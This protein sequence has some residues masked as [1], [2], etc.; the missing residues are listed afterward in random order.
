M[1]RTKIDNHTEIRK[2]LLSNGYPPLANYDKRCFLENWPNLVIDAALVTSR[3]WV[4]R[5][6]AT[7]IRND[8][9]SFL[10]VD[11][12]DPALNAAIVS[13]LFALFPSGP[14]LERGTTASCKKGFLFRCE[15]AFGILRSRRYTLPGS[16]EVQ[17]VEIFSCGPN[18]QIGGFGA[19]KRDK[20]GTIL[21]EYVWP[22]DSPLDVKLID[23]PLLTEQLA[24]LM[25]EAAEQVFTD[26]GCVPVPGSEREKGGGQDVYDLT[27]DMVFECQ[28]GVARTLAGLK[29]ALKGTDNIRCSSSWRGEGFDNTTACIARMDRQGRLLVTDFHNDSKHHE[30]AFR[31]VEPEEIRLDEASLQQAEPVAEV[32][33]EH[34][35][36]AI[37]RQ[38][39]ALIK[40]SYAYCKTSKTPIVPLDA[41]NDDDCCTLAN[42][43]ISMLPYCG[44]EIGPR[45]GVRKINPVDIWLTDPEHIAIRGKQMRPDIPTQLFTEQGHQ[46]LNTYHAPDH[47]VAGG[48]ATLLIQFMEQIA[49]DEA[50]RNYF[51]QWLAYKYRHPWVPGPGIVMVARNKFGTGRGRLAKLI[52]KLFGPAYVRRLPFHI[53]A[54]KSYQ[55]QY[56]TYA[57]ESLF[58]IVNETQELQGQAKWSVSQDTYAHIRE[59]IEPSA[60]PREII[61][62]GVNARQMLSFCSY[63]IMLNDISSIPIPEEDRRLGALENGEPQP[64]A[65]WLALEQAMADPANIA[66]FARWLLT[67]DLTGYSPFTTP[68]MTDTK[69]DMAWAGLSD[70]E[71]TLHDVLCYLKGR[72]EIFSLAH[73]LIGMRAL[74]H[75]QHLPQGWEQV[76]PKIIQQKF[77]RIGTADGA[78]WKPQFFGHRHPA[79]AWAAG[80]AK[81]WTNMDPG[82]I[83]AELRKAGPD[84]T[85]DFGIAVRNFGD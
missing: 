82:F 51:L 69:R 83:R 44:D 8:N 36:M 78:N 27:D 79:Y 37:A 60:E 67:I 3:D 31:P 61:S 13:V 63:L 19:H 42:F 55:S 12:S 39:A 6:S 72:S 29:A 73:I 4:K 68:P 18:R 14:V 38:A 46:W 5:R 50:S 54:G 49:P 62:K 45:G 81:K 30:A 71:Q 10:D 59:V 40:R 58:V 26:L 76:V 41:I 75:P 47:S 1:S 85:I 28:D 84:D 80:M 7:G 21:S 70:L 15:E 11:V 9:S 52:E 66:A 23:L 74:D 33:A 65:Y 16:D 20:D 43:R 48:D 32:P 57:A 17:V 2:L 22:G 24:L 64:E 77:Y 35:S 56:N 53:F 25:I 34:P